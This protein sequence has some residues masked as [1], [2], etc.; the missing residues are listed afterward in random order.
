MWVLFYSLYPCLCFFFCFC[1][2]FHSKSS[3]FVVC[4]CAIPTT[5]KSVCSALYHN[6]SVASFGLT[7]FCCF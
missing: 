5:F 6:R 4:V 3:S 2:P 1:K 7:I